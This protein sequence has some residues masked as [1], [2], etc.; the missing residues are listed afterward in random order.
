ME[1]NGSKSGYGYSQL[2]PYSEKSGDAAPAG[3]HSNPED[4][5]HLI[6]KPMGYDQT[7]YTT[8]YQDNPTPVVVTT[9]HVYVLPG[10]H[11]QL[12]RSYCGQIAL[13]CF[14]FWCC[15]W[16]L[17]L[18]AFILAMVANNSRDTGHD[19]E[20]KKLGKAS[21]IASISG[22]IIGTIL[23]FIFIIVYVNR[24]KVDTSSSNYPYNG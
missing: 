2:P 24:A 21:W 4:T 15:C 10:I 9:R 3:I 20:A 22:I 1:N 12:Q 6:E 19:Q 14:V 5:S 7:S 18:V 23:I 16:P 13:S 17:G 11:I 8:V